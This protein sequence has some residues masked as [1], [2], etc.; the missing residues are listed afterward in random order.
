LVATRYNPV[1]KA[2]DK[3]LLAAGTLK[4]VA[5]TACM[6]T[7][8][9]IMHAMVRDMPPWQPRELSIA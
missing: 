6:H 3:R 4:K 8:L 1:I 2:F 5:W 9:T 7:L